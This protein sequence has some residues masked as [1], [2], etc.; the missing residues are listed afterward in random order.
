MRKTLRI[1]VVLILASV[2][3]TSSSVA[4]HAIFGLSTCERVQ[5][6]IEGYETEFN[7]LAQ[8]VFTYRGNEFNK[9]STLKRVVENFRTRGDELLFLRWKAAYNNKKCLTATQR[10]YVKA[11]KDQRVEGRYLLIEKNLWFKKT[12][13][14]RG[15]FAHTTPQCEF[16]EDDTIK[17]VYIIANLYGQ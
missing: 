6:E 13:K 7:S 8:R 1:T 11:I 9:S 15:I 10:D 17:D 5:K 12:K 14:C 2:T 16:A 3:L 4:A